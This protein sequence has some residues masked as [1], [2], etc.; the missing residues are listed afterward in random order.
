MSDV[1]LERRFQ[2]PLTA[3][4]VVTLTLA[5]GECFDRHRVRWRGSLLARDGRRMLCHFQA[6][7]AESTRLALHQATADAELQAA[8]ARYGTTVTGLWPGTVHDAPGLG[9]DEIATANVL[10]ERAFD[11]PVSLAAIQALE[12]AGAACLSNH[13]VRFVRTLFARNARRMICLYHAPDAESVRLAQRQAGMPVARVWA[14]HA[15]VPPD[16]AA[17]PADA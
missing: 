12:D 13:R 11:A 7:D 1:F 2:T 15:V 5:A 9:A 3:D 6:P 10:V 16:H 17:A 14:F 4:T 8:I